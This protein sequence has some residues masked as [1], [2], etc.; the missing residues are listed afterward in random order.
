MKAS[1]TNAYTI[2]PTL[3]TPAWQFYHEDHTQQPHNLRPPYPL[4]EKVLGPLPGPNP[5]P[6]ILLT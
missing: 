4:Y 2:S 6:G 1:G 3:Q 5:G